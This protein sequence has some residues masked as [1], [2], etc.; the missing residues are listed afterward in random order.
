MGLKPP[1]FSGGSS[2]F[3]SFR[4]AQWVELW[5]CLN[6]GF[7]F[8]KNDFLCQD[9]VWSPGCPFLFVVKGPL[10]SALDSSSVVAWSFLRG[11]IPVSLIVL[12]QFLFSGL[13]SA[14]SNP[15]TAAPRRLDR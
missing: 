10:L 1:V 2:C 6:F 4:S 5:T 8:P 3:L 15:V 11:W 13:F 14:S 9:S 7:P 12:G